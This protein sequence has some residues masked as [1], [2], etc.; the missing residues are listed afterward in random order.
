M[1]NKIISLLVCMLMMTTIPLAAGST[2]PEPAEPEQIFDRV[3][4]SGLLFNVKRV[5]NLYH[6]QVIRLRWY[7]INP[8]GDRAGGLQ[9]LPDVVRFNEAPGS[10]YRMYE[11][12]LGFFT[13]VFG[14]FK[15][16]EVT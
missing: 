11:F 16:F 1:K 4:M 3:L 13:I 7:E 2:E 12:G 8:F 14:L 5:G 10:F 15:N 6:A 9:T